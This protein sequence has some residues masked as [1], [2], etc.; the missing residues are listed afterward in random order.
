MR[1]Y[2]LPA[3][4]ILCF[5]IASW[6]VY[7][8]FEGDSCADAG[9]SFSSLAAQCFMAPSETYIPLH[10]K[11]TWAFWVLYSLVSLVTGIV[12]TGFLGGIV[13][14][15]RSLRFDVLRGPRQRA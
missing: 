3:A 6:L 12:L 13:A 4:V 9:G 10:R 8:F 11:A 5:G 7:L 1:K 14:G 15:L 2:L